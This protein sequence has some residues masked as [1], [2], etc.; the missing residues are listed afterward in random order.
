MPVDVPQL[1]FNSAAAFGVGV[2]WYEFTKILIYLRSGDK[3]NK[4]N[5]ENKRKKEAVSSGDFSEEDS[6]YIYTIDKEREGNSDDRWR[7]V[8]RKKVEKKKK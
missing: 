7:L 3:G 8:I 4:G 2:L 5:E 1:L 6:S